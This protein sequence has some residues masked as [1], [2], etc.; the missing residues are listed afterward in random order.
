MAQ[1]GAGTIG[2]MGGGAA[3]ATWP[4]LA[5]SPWADTRDT[6]HMW[7]QIVGKVRLAL[8]PMVNHWWQVPLYVSARGLTTSLMPAGDRGLEIEF[9]FI[10]HV[11]VLRDT[12]GEVRRFGLQGSSVADFYAR[13]LAALDD[14]RVR[15]PVRGVPVEVAEAVPF[16]DDTG[17]HA[18]DPDAIHRFWQA[19]VRVHDVF[20]RFR[21]RYV[22]KVS[23]VHFFWGGFDLAVTRFSGRRAPEHPGGIPNCPDWVMRAAYS[24]EVSSCGFFPGEDARGAFY[25]YAYPEPDGFAGWPVRPDQARYDSA[26][27]EFL[28]PYE[29]VRTAADPAATLLDFLQDTYEAA[30]VLGGW[31][32]AALEAGSADVEP[33]RQPVG[34]GR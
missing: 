6:V 1:A 29:A 21:S 5:S 28:L 32:R 23:P 19:L 33:Q 3:P 2:D 20:T 24:H 30:A 16:A 22:G 9:D 8:E 17:H 10:D 12:A 14:L 34:G 7:T 27:G 13:T 31:D 25:A 18:Y 11:L 26:L 15:V 4:D